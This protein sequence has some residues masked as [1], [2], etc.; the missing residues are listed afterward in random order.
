MTAVS[1][2]IPNKCEIF[3]LT[4]KNKPIIST[5]EKNKNNPK[6]KSTAVI[7]IKLSML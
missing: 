4:Y 2:N 1:L 5:R 3:V 7:P 6:E